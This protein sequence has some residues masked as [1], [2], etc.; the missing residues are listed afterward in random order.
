MSSPKSAPMNPSMSPHTRENLR[1]LWIMLVLFF[2]AWIPR[3]V[4]LDA[5]VTVDERKWLARSANFLYALAH[6]DFANTFQREHPGV[7]VMWAGALGILQTFPDFLQKAPGYF[8]WDNQ[9]I[10][11]W[12]KASSTHTPLELLVAGR[13]WI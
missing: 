13:W 12:L 10:E 5:F 9:M 6:G 3:V 8:T 4:A 11:A 2:C 7:T 1:T